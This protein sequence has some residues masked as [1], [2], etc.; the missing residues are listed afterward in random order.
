M[1]R[2]IEEC[3][4]W[5]ISTACTG[6]LKSDVNMYL[7]CKN[8]SILDNST[9]KILRPSLIYTLFP[10]SASSAAAVLEMVQQGCGGFVNFDSLHIISIVAE[11]PGALQVVL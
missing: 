4:R 2:C 11:T 10:A 3:I 9:T 5:N 7:L 6:A 1:I 8:S